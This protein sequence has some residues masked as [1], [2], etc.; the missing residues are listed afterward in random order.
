MFAARASPPETSRIMCLTAES[1]D[2]RCLASPRTPEKRLPTPCRTTPTPFRARQSPYVLIRIGI[3]SLS[4]LTMPLGN[5]PSAGTLEFKEADTL[6]QITN[7]FFTT[8]KIGL[9]SQ[10]GRGFVLDRNTNRI[11]Q[12][13][14]GVFDRLFPEPRPPAPYEK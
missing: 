11:E 4:L 14:I 1:D 2:S 5:P 8:T 13:D 9:L 10:D 7:M 3:V 12:S 6:P